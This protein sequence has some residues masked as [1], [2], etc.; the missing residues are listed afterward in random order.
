MQPGV[1]KNSQRKWIRLWRKG[2]PTSGVPGPSDG[3]IGTKDVSTEFPISM[4]MVLV[5]ACSLTQSD[6]LLWTNGFFVQ[7]HP[8]T[9]V[10][11]SR[12]RMRPDEAGPE[13]WLSLASLSIAPFAEI[14]PTNR[15]AGIMSETT[16]RKDRTVTFPLSSNGI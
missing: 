3:A 6:V 14:L 7:A 8:P 2:G 5:Q 16:V 10:D 11:F 9:S 12:K 13:R 1:R 15:G 4:A